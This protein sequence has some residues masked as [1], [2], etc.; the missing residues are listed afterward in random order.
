MNMNNR[1]YLSFVVGPTIQVLHTM[2]MMII[3]KQLAVPRCNKPC[4]P[5]AILAAVAL[6]LAAAAICRCF[7]ATTRKQKNHP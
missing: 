3:M 2:I 6:T 4:V 5:L 1:I 7:F